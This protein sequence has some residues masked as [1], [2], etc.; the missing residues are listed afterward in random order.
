MTSATTS[1]TESFES[2]M[3]FALSH[4]SQFSVGSQLTQ[5]TEPDKHDPL[6][7][8]DLGKP[9]DTNDANIVGIE[10]ICKAGLSEQL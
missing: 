5:L 3:S 2:E 9:V 7:I 4:T 1:L 10:I 8:P 6:G